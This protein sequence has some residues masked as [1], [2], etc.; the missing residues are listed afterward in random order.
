MKIKELREK[1]KTELDNLLKDK[2]EALAKFR[3]EMG[4]GKV[5]NTKEAREIKKDMARILTLM[6]AKGGK[7]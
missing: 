6:S 7:K 3:V 4:H 2:K 5:K 1:T